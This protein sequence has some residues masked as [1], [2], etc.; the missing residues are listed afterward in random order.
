MEWPL[1]QKLLSFI[2]PQR[3]L[4]LFDPTSRPLISRVSRWIISS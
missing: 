2:F 4:N 3:L 1:F